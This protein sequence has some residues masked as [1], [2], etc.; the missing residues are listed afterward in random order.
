MSFGPKFGSNI[1]GGLI[2][3]A[4]GISILGGRWMQ[5]GISPEGILS[6]ASGSFGQIV[7][8]PPGYI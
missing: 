4:D 6:L 8:D 3:C 1:V 7:T 5:L 2:Q